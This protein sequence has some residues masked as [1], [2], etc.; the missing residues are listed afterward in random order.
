MNYKESGSECDDDEYDS[1]SEHSYEIVK[2]ED[3]RSST[4]ISKISYSSSDSAKF[5]LGPK[6]KIVT[7]HLRPRAKKDKKTRGEYLFDY[8]KLL[9]RA[10]VCPSLI[11]DQN[12][13]FS[14]KK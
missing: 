14:F 9:L 2:C 4:P 8:E 7:H 10:R 12:F 1:S 3:N 5:S 11:T 13:N 6:G